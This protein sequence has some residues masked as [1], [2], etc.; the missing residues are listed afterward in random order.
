[1]NDNVNNYPQ[2]TPSV[3]RPIDSQP[4]SSI[5]ARKNKYLSIIGIVLVLI[6]FS[7]GGYFLGYKKGA[8]L[9]DNLKQSTSSPTVPTNSQQP[10]NI[11]T[12]TT[13]QEPVNNSPQPTTSVTTKTLSYALPIGWKTIQDSTGAFEIGY[14][15]NIYK[16]TQNNQSIMLAYTAHPG[17]NTIALVSYDGG[18]LHQAI[19]KQLGYD[20]RAVAI[21]KNKDYYEKEYSYSGWRCLVMYGLNYSASGNVWGICAVS[22]DKA[23]FFSGLDTPLSTEQFIQTF[24]YLKS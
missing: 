22:S 3:E 10:S 6:L 20:A 9:S 21:E 18:S 1:M 7:A 17:S 8:Q 23:L 13:S 24:K 14:D 11:I 5:V 4:S 2:Q 19:Y 12:P 16:P 15:Q